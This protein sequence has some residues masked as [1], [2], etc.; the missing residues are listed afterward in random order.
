MEATKKWRS[1]RC[2]SMLHKTR[3]I[4]HAMTERA[5]RRI[6]R[7]PN[8]SHTRNMIKK[9]QHENGDIILF[10]L[11][12]THHT[13]L[14]QNY[15][16]V[17]HSLSHTNH[18][19]CHHPLCLFTVI[20]YC[21]PGQRFFGEILSIKRLWRIDQMCVNLW[22]TCQWIAGDTFF[23]AKKRVSVGNLQWVDSWP[24]LF[25]TCFIVFH[26]PGHCL[27]APHLQEWETS[28][29]SSSTV[30]HTTATVSS[31]PWY[32]RSGSTFPLP[33]PSSSLIHISS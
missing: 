6:C 22:Y 14:F 33:P 7:Q 20:T 23:L 4:L 5:R 12:N 2:S 13:A 15:N 9:G 11:T 19:E 28:Y 25:V 26:P 1:R 18:S 16:I 32:I 24:T 27:I 30:L 10:L 21:D 29:F 17:L 3:L 8:R 31:M